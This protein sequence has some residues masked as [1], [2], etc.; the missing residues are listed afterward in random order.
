MRKLTTIMMLIAFFVCAVAI[1]AEDSASDT[2]L[3]FGWEKVFYAIGVVVA[4]FVTALLKKL[5][6]KYGIEISG[7]QEELVKKYALDAIAYADEWAYK[8]LKIDEIA[9]KSEA[10]FEKAVAKLI[11]KVP[12]LDPEKAKDVIVS[13]L[14]E[15]RVYL[16]GKIDSIIEEKLK[17]NGD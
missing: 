16:G 8:K 11:E 7:A 17:K 14:P 6:K 13:K 9:V 10:K 4:G 3:Q 2:W 15:F 12:G 1:G 5:G